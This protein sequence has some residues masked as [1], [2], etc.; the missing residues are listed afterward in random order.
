MK[1]FESYVADLHSLLNA[2]VNQPR[3]KTKYAA[4]IKAALDG[5]PARELRRLVP[6]ETLRSQG[7]FFTGSKLALYALHSALNSISDNSVILDP[8]CGAGDLL[9]ASSSRLSIQNDL[10]RTLCLWGKSLI[11]R[12]LHPEFILATKIR[13]VLAAIKRGVPLGRSSFP[14]LENL[15]PH[16]EVRSGITDYEAFGQASHIFINP[17]FSMV[18]APKTCTWASGMVNFAALFL[19]ACLLNSRTGTRVIAILPDV[20]RSGSRYQKWRELIVSRSHLNKI[21]LFG[22]FD[23]WADVDVFIMDAHVTNNGKLRKS[24]EWGYPKQS[25]GKLLGD[26]FE[27]AIGPVVSYRDPHL[28]PWFPFVQARGLKAWGTVSDIPVSRRFLGRA[29]DPPFVVVRRT[30]RPG[31][32]YRAIGTIITGHKSVAVENHL[33]ILKPRDN[34]LESCEFLLKILTRQEVNK[35]LDQRIRCR[36]LTVSSLRELP[37]VGK[38]ADE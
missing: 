20:L 6:L 38:L 3:S 32:K 24:I 33:I 16:L 37:M 31:D 14:D 12:D 15:F 5:Q 11:G 1:A 36:H 29:F 27:I 13:L 28:G 18:E 34:K 25:E 2:A 19:E 23:R 8:A 4:H 17:P 22:K 7:A 26:L 30:S 35:W 10:S 21:K 9:I